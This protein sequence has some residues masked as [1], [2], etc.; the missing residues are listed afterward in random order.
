[1]NAPS[2]KHRQVAPR[3]LPLGSTSRAQTAFSAALDRL[4]EP[5]ENLQE[6]SFT[7]E[8][9]P[10][11]RTT[12][13]PENERSSNLRRIF[14]WLPVLIAR[15]SHSP[16]SPYRQIRA[17]LGFGAIALVVIASIWFIGDN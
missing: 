10:P 15:L 16:C 5:L 2:V 1:M 9:V 8:P 14:W 17:V 12:L 11:L 13:P 4:L 3:N 6:E 7:S